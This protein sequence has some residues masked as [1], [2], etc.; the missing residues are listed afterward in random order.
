MVVAHDIRLQRHAG[1]IGQLPAEY[2]RHAVALGLDMIP[3]CLS[4]LTDQVQPIGQCARFVH[5]TGGIE[6]SAL[7]ALVVELAADCHPALGLGLLGYH[8][9]GAAG[10][11]ATV[12]GRSRSPQHF[13]AFD[14]VGVRSVRVAAVDGK[15]VA[16]E[17]AG[18]EPADGEAGQ[19]LVAEVVGAPDAAGIVECILQAC[20]AAVL[21]RFTGDDADRLRCLVQRGVGACRACR[22]SCTVALYGAVGAFRTC[23][24][25]IDGRCF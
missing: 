14:V 9:E 23:G 6:R 12:E 7:H 22:S 21:D 15:A 25:C 5:S 16:I 4:T 17:L 2:R 24:G 8:V 10:I 3:E 20:C 19:A 18:V 11:A 1:G 13:D